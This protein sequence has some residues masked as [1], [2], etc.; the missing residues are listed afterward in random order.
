MFLG[1]QKR[2]PQSKFKNL[3]P[4]KEQPQVLTSYIRNFFKVYHI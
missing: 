2:F 3:R 4:F 1:S